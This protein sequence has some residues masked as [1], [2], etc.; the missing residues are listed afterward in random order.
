MPDI[1]ML[2]VKHHE[3]HWVHDGSLVIGAVDSKKTATTLFRVHR[4]LL[5]DQSEVFASMFS[6]PQGEESCQTDSYEG[7]PFVQ[8]P[9]TSEEVAVLLDALRDPMYVILYFE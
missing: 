1:P 7:L 6:L 9:D 4:T 2:P 5:T 8:L 3:K